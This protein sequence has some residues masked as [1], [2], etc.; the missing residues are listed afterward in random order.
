[1]NRRDMMKLA[2]LGTT[3]SL[4]IPNQA[5]SFFLDPS[6]TKADFGPNFKWG[7]ATAAYQIE[8]A[9]QEDGRGLSIWDTFSHQK[10][11][12]KTGEN[13][14]VSA[15][16]YHRY[17]DD[18]ALI[19]AMNMNVNRFSI[20]WSRIMP[21]GTGA[22][23]QKGIDFY[24][25]VIDRTLE[26]GLEPWITCYH[27]DLPQALQDKGGWANRDCIGWFNDYVDVISKAYGDKVK[28]WMV[29]NEPMAF[30]AVGYLM[31]I[32]APGYRNFKKFYAATHHAAMAQA[33]GARVI[34]SNVSGSN[35]GSTFSCSAVMP[36]TNADKHVKAAAKMDSLVNRLFIEP[37]V[38]KGYPVNDWKLLENIYKYV[39]PGDEEKLVA[40]FDF[41]GIQNYTRIM[42]K[43]SLWPPILW[44]NQVKPKNLVGPED[45]TDMGWEVYPEGIHQVLKQFAA[46]P[47]IDKIIV[48]ENGAAFPDTVEGNSVHDAK[49][50]DF[51]KKYLAQVLKA[52]QE[53]VNIQGYFCWTL[54]D[55]FEWAEG[56]K[57]RFGLVHVDFET[58]KR[59]MKDS[60]LW[61]KEFLK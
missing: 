44:A 8:G 9:Y 5:Y 32:H 41:I 47:G 54:M 33:E 55:N 3:G 27:W 58:Q 51:Y 52:K 22:V 34:R 26:L 37:A 10:K 48:T 20:S 23:N 12:I 56:Y 31:G 7:V 4:L 53:G 21:E 40:N 45:I 30:V 11:N 42:V 15:D 17:Y 14:D 39:Q 38:G 16:F 24:H 13:G 28:N 50:V 46:Y 49:R 1:M 6:F 25:K 18:I 29:L 60:G 61:F 59:T 43:H 57:P 35:V 2:A 36:K 19:K